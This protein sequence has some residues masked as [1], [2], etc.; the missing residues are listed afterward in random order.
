MVDLIIIFIICGHCV[1]N[2][3]L[4]VVLF[5]C[6]LNWCYNSPH[7]QDDPRLDKL[8]EDSL[9]VP[10]LASWVANGLLQLIP[11]LV[12]VGDTAHLCVG[13]GGGGRGEGEGR[14]M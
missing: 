7:W 5:C 9:A 12:G 3:M 11:G 1:P 14:D 8:L 13:E 6:S 4:V 2:D 10:V